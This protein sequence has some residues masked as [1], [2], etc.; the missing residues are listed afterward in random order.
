MGRV[1][2]KKAMISGAASGIG[3]AIARALAAEGADV[4]LADIDLPAAQAA[5]A[6]IGGTALAIRLDVRDEGEWQG[7]MDHVLAV[8]GRLD[9]LVNNA[10]I[11]RMGSIEDA[12]LEDWR[13]IHAVNSEGVFLGCKYGV[14]AMKSTG[15]SIIN[16]ASIAALVGTPH[17]VA[18]AAS[19]AGVH[20][21]T[22]CVALHCARQGYGIRCNSVHPSFI[23]T[24]MVATMVAGHRDPDG[25]RASLDRGNPL[26]SIGRPEDVAGMVVYLAADESAF[27]TGADMVVDGG[28]TAM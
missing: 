3:L 8:H 21:L 5:A 11:L 16:M 27:V 19:K 2:S 7:A 24:P 23:D 6:A 1:A 10:G 28:T 20:L 18:Y 12:S 13:Q 17:L 4:V 22:K 26:G 25:L 15:G 9:I 14:A